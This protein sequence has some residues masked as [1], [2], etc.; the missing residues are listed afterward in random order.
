MTKVMIKVIN[1]LYKTRDRAIETTAQNCTRFLHLEVV[2]VGT[3]QAL[4]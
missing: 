3:T 2:A 4:N 1:T